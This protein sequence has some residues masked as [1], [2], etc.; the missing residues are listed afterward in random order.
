MNK[1]QKIVLDYMIK[2]ALK[3]LHTE[4]LYSSEESTKHHLNHLINEG[5]LAMYDFGSNLYNAGFVAKYSYSTMEK[6]NKA[7]YDFSK[8]DNAFSNYFLTRKEEILKTIF[9]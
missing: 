3:E 5:M 2:A 1:K 6:I 8:I 4:F 7:E 9:K